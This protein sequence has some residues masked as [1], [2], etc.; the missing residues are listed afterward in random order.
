MIS[1][2]RACD[3]VAF[4]FDSIRGL[5]TKWIAEE[6]NSKFMNIVTFLSGTNTA[7]S[8]TELQMLSE[9][10]SGSYFGQKVLSQLALS[11]GFD[12][13]FNDVDTISRSLETANTDVLTM[14]NA[15]EGNANVALTW[16]NEK[17]PDSG[18]LHLSGL[19]MDYLTR[20]NSTLAEFEI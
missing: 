17:N 2:E 12:I 1:A 5:L 7:I 4:E 19:A 13:Q 10:T 6:P 11:Q 16:I 9:L 20:D 8:K 15:Y 14:I 3:D 18:N